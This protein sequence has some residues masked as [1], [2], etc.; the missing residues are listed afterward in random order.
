MA[1][2]ADAENALAALVANALYPDGTDAASVTGLVCRVYRGFPNPTALDADLA[3][4]IVHVSVTAGDGTVRNVTRYPRQWRAVKPVAQVLSVVV[5]GVC[6]T[7]S[8]TCAVGQLAGVL[9][10][11]QTFAY[12][13]QASDS[14][15]TVASNLAAMIRAAGWIVNYAGSGLT[16][17]G[18]ERFTAR[19]VAGAGALQ[20]IKRQ[21]QDFK[22]TMW[23]PNPAAR[24]TV[25]RVIDAALA[26][27]KF[28]PLADGSSGHM[29]FAGTATQDG[30][31]ETCLFRRELTYAVEYP[32]TLAQMAPAMLFGTVTAMADAVVLGD[33]QS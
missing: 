17:P 3:A 30:G 2:Q 26:T 24:D 23:C 13:V 7:F 18:A 1:D 12:A 6:A 15:A 21:V 25:A 29:V 27:V 31:A 9:V 4:G 8:G 20:E 11:K 33:F 22:V 32:T 14:P 5:Q 19:V 16:V 28:I 10:N